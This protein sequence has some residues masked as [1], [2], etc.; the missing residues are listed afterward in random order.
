[1]LVLMLMAESLHLTGSLRIP[2][3]IITGLLKNVSCLH[4]MAFKEAGGYLRRATPVYTRRKLWGLRW[5]EASDKSASF[6]MSID[7]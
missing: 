7:E 4:G 2:G 6:Q 5:R 3:W 1:M